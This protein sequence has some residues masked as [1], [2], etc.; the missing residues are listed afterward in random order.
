MFENS[1]NN[2]QENYLKKDKKDKILLVLL[3]FWTPLIPPLGISCIKSYLQGHGYPVTAVDANSDPELWEEYY[4]YTGALK[5]FIPESKRGNFY[6]IA[7]NILRNHSMAYLNRRDESEYR[8][9]IKAIIARDY[10]CEITD[11]QVYELDNILETFYAKLKEYIYQ[12]LEKQ[13]PAVVGISVFSGSLPASIFAFKLIKE[14]SQHIKTVMGGGVFAD[15]LAV[16]SPGFKEFV[17]KAPYIDKIIA[18]EGE[19]LFL[20]YLQGELPE[21]QKVYTLQDNNNEYLDFSTVDIPD[22]SD[23]DIQDYPQLSTYVSRS[24]VYQCRFCSETVSWGKFRK[25][26]IKQAVDEFVKLY[27]KHGC[28][29]FLL[30]DSMLNP[31]IAE[32]SDELIK[33]DLSFYWDGYLRADKHVCSYEN[34]IKWRRAGFYRA[35]LGVESGSQRVLNLMDKRITPEQIKAAVSS[36]AH[37]GIKTTTYWVIGY[38]GESEEDFQ[39]TL[40]L[41]KELKEDIWEAECNKFWYFPSA[42]TGSD[43]WAKEDGVDLLYPKKLSDMLMVQTWIVNAEPSRE[44]IHDRVCRFT[45]HCRKLGIPNTYTLRDVY[46]ADDR[47]KK[48]HKNA[49]PLITE[50]KNKR[51]FVDE[52]KRIIV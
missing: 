34:T 8:E 38:P 49:V 37:A 17:N 30:G 6:N 1:T 33:R 47:W 44:V 35:R 9:L 14:H 3:P 51:V 41:I 20:K 15:Q 12:L 46:F 31:F 43:K 4:N 2:L 26:E 52:N 48:L 42:Q 27:K 10:F 11:A 5:K 36:L 25:K 50:F 19:V 39:E 24:C 16:S 18:G 40:D 29:L 22:F 7:H 21:T 13:K 45:E 23:F 28:Q 32:L